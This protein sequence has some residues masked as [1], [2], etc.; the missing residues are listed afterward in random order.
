M[1]NLTTSKLIK[2]FNELSYEPVLDS[3]SSVKVKTKLNRFESIHKYKFCYILIKKAWI[4][5]HNNGLFG[6]FINGSFHAPIEEQLKSG[7]STF[8]VQNPFDGKELARVFNCDEKTYNSAVDS[9]RQ[10]FG[11]W[12]QMSYVERGRIIYK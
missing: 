1:S 4:K 9:N 8:Q 5:S 7:T 11:T 12:S 2:V 3:D 6:A 10:A